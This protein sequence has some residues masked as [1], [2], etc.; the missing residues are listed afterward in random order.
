MCA[1]AKSEYKIITEKS[2]RAL[3][4]HRH[5]TMTV[6]FCC[7]HMQPQTAF[8]LGSEMLLRTKCE[9]LCSVGMTKNSSSNFPEEMQ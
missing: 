1:T 5:L 7:I 4:K 6:K 8:L 2:L 9:V 3:L